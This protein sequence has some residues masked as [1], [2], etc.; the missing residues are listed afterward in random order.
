[1]TTFTPT[2]NTNSA[3]VLAWEETRF[4]V[5]TGEYV[6]VLYCTTADGASF[7]TGF[8]PSTPETRNNFKVKGD[9]WTRI[10]QVPSGAEFIGRY[11]TPASLRIRA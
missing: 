8:R 2:P 1:M 7:T 5:S 11:E 4:M 10:D 9:V 6:A 3:L